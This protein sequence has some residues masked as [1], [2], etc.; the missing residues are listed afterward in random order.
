[1][2]LAAGART[3]RAPLAVRTAQDGVRR[4]ASGMAARAVARV[5]RRPVER[6]TA[7]KRRLSCARPNPPKMDG[8]SQRKTELEL[9]LVGHSDVSGVARALAR[10]K[11]LGPC[12]ALDRCGT[13]SN[14]K[15]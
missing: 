6:A 8:A 9:P 15:R 7:S 12:Q 3:L 5:E 11:A 14:K 2:D 10:R 4:T 1:M 13:I